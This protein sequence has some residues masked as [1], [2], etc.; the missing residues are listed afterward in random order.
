MSILEATRLTQW[1]ITTIRQEMATFLTGLAT[2]GPLV[3]PSQVF[4]E[5]VQRVTSLQKTLDDYVERYR[6]LIPLIELVQRELEVADP[7]K[8]LPSIKPAP[9]QGTT[10]TG[11]SGLPPTTGPTAKRPRKRS[12][13]KKSSA[14]NTPQTGLTPRT[15]PENGSETQP[16]LL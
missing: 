13:V 8:Q 12:Y 11:G 14:A 7:E 5:N 16:I 10:A 1:Q 6:K 3:N 4:E 15:I 9:L 2:I